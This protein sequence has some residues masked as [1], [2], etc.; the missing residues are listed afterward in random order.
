MQLRTLTG[1]GLVLLAALLIPSG[2]AAAQGAAPGEMVFPVQAGS[3]FFTGP[4]AAPVTIITWL[5]YQ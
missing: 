4:P 3:S 1:P 2:P 5:D